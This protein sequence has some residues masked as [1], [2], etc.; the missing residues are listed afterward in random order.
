MKMNKGEYMIK[1]S[2]GEITINDG[3]YVFNNVP[4]NNGIIY[5]NNTTLKISRWNI[6]I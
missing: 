6:Y 1:T 4:Y 2:G 3:N 5:S